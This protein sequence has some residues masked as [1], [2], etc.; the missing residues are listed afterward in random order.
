ML[1]LVA[2]TDKQKELSVTNKQGRIVVLD[3]KREV[4]VESLWA[5]F[6][7]RSDE[8]TLFRSVKNLTTASVV[9]IT[10]ALGNRWFIPNPRLDLIFK[11]EMR[12]I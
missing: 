6:G 5:D 8:E 9:E 11:V 1:F 12:E 4:V 10:D 3:A 7:G 2:A